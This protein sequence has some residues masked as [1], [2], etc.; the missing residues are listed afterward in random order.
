MGII[1]LVY[2]NRKRLS[3]DALEKLIN[4]LEE[5]RK[6]RGLLRD[7]EEGLKDGFRKES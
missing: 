1:G 4:M 6:R 2:T 3:E 7:D 5:E